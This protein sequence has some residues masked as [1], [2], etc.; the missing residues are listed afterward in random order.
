VSLHFWPPRGVF[1]ACV[2]GVSEGVGTKIHRVR[3]SRPFDELSL[4]LSL[5]TLAALAG[6]AVT[7]SRLN[8]SSHLEI[9][10]WPYID[11]AMAARISRS[12]GRSI[13]RAFLQLRSELFRC[14]SNVSLV[15][16]SVTFR[17][18]CGSESL[19]YHVP[20]QTWCRSTQAR[21]VGNKGASIFFRNQLLSGREKISVPPC[22]ADKSIRLTRSCRAALQEGLHVSL[23]CRRS[24]T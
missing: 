22:T 12:T 9:Y 7:I 13:F 19:R 21:G 1:S 5:R 3:H 10:S 6:G 20:K 2:S 16:P 15:L 14:A 18:T 8:A 24:A 17:I 11:N 23:I 4:S